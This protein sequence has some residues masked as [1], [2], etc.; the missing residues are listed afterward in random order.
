MT[1]PAKIQQKLADLIA[2]ISPHCKLH[3]CGLCD[4]A[5]SLNIVEEEL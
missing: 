2:D 1:V 5:K 3:W 4:F